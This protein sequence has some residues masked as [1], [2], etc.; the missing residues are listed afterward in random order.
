MSRHHLLLLATLSLTGCSDAITPP[1]PLGLTSAYM[2]SSGQ[3]MAS[4]AWK[5]SCDGTA[6]FI[7]PSTLLITGSCQFAPGG[8]FTVVTHEK[9]N[10][11]A[12]SAINQYTAPNGDVLS[13]TSEGTFLPNSDGRGVTFTG[14][15]TIVGGTGRFHNVAGSAVRTGSTLFGNPSTGSYELTGT[16]AGWGK[17]S[18]QGETDRLMQK[19]M[20][21]S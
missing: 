2:S 15:E 4:R 19:E 8:R 7:G 10:G 9:L 17:R 13:T 5:A 3:P 11:F 12:L 1:S 16:I 14:I 18:N 6:V 20:R 21:G